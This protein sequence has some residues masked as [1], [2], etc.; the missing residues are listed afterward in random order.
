MTTLIK[1]TY[2]ILGNDR[3]L[4]HNPHIEYKFEFC[5]LLEGKKKNNSK[6]NSTNRE[7]N[8]LPLSGMQFKRT[9][10]KGQHAIPFSIDER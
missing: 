9:I 1:G 8:P 6:A 10:R 2:L 4:K 5:A 3:L 7:K